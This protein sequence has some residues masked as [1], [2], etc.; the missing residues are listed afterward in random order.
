MTV[1]GHRYPLRGFTHLLETGLSGFM[2]QGRPYSWSDVARLEIRPASWIMDLTFASSA[3]PCTMVYLKDGG[4]LRIQGRYLEEE[5]SP[6]GMDPAGDGTEA[7]VSLR[8]LFE[9]AVN[10]PGGAVPCQATAGGI[11]S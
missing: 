2:V 11:P 4:H 9:T 7:Y 3:L 1:Y 5:G 8:R 10:D 6:A